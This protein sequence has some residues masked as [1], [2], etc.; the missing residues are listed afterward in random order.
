MAQ[1][2]IG[3][4]DCHRRRRGGTDSLGNILARSSAVA[5]RAAF[6]RRCGA[7]VS[8]STRPRASST[9]IP[10]PCYL[11]HLSSLR[12]P[13]RRTARRLA[14]GTALWTGASAAPAAAVLPARETPHRTSLA[15]G[16]LL[17][18]H[19]RIPAARTVP[20]CNQ[21]RRSRQ[22]RLSLPPAAPLSPLRA[23]HLSPQATR[24]PRGWLGG[25]GRAN[26][27]GRLEGGSGTC[28]FHHTGDRYT[29]ETARVAFGSKRGAFYPQRVLPAVVYKA[30]AFTSH[31]WWN[32]WRGSN[33]A[34]GA[35]DAGLLRAPAS[36]TLYL[37]GVALVVF[38]G[39]CLSIVIRRSVWK[40]GWMTFMRTRG[41]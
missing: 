27:H 16:A 15:S 8:L 29:E 6:R 12:L 17:C 14:A 41:T 34:L 18:F 10:S 19:Q 2:V 22:S 26:G 40:N 24:T 21:T 31:H 38:F 37:D 20:R 25:V 3:F 4:F 9:L 1:A 13:T 30:L 32:R 28:E 39:A 23:E 11:R 36:C 35:G 7:G 5:E 33:Y